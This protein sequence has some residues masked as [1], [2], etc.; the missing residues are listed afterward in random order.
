[1]RR[2]GDSAGF[3]PRI[4]RMTRGLWSRA[5]RSLAQVPLPNAVALLGEGARCLSRE[6]PPSLAIVNC[7]T[8]RR[9]VTR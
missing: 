1:M 9:G 6:I 4:A 8:I 7:E 5:T 2:G 3:E